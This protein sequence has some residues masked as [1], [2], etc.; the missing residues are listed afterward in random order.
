MSDWVSG[1]ITLAFVATLSA[2]VSEVLRRHVGTSAMWVVAGC[3]T[4]LMGFA[5]VTETLRAPEISAGSERTWLLLSM[6]LTAI[7]GFLA[8]TYGVW[9]GSRTQSVGYLRQ[10]GRGLIAAFGFFILARLALWVLDRV[11]LS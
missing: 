2:V 6:S 7:A 10:T 4:L 11:V 9:V 8:P 5:L 1:L 3:A